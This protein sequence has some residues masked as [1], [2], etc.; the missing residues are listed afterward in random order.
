MNVLFHLNIRIRRHFTNSLRPKYP[1]MLVRVYGLNTYSRL[2]SSMP[3]QCQR[4]LTI[5]GYIDL[6]LCAAERYRGS[7][8][9]R[10]RQS[11]DTNG[12]IK[13]GEESMT[14]TSLAP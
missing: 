9:V 14:S 6:K 5:T 3:K 13:A 12:K 11:S 7:R 1:A 10:S 8:N 4:G 2:V